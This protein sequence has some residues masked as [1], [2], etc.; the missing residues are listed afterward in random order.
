M[1]E[2][3]LV[4]QRSR[5]EIDSQLKNNEM[6]PTTIPIMVQTP[7]QACTFMGRKFDQNL[8]NILVYVCVKIRLD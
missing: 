8:L 5:A 6:S 7:T 2:Q 3:F 4:L 1:A